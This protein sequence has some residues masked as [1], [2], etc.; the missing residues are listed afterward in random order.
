MRLLLALILLCSMSPASTSP[1]DDPDY[2]KHLLAFNDPYGAFV[3]DLLGCPVLA[4]D[5]EQCNS[6]QGGINWPAYRDAAKLVR[7][8]FPQ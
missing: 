1:M 7:K 6:K 8:V 2:I 3:R 5:I 4:T